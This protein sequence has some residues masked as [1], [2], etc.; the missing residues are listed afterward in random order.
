LRS[1]EREPQ[2]RQTQAG[3]AP[4]PLTGVGEANGRGG[5]AVAVALR[6]EPN[7]RRG[8]RRNLFLRVGHV[9]EN[10]AA[11]PNGEAGALEASKALLGVQKKPL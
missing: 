7:S 8:S 5:Q 11:V 6:G 4:G 1:W 9:E 3:V 10:R 2:G